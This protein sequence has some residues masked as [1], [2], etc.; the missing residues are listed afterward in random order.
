MSSAFRRLS[1]S[2]QTWVEI[3]IEGETIR[4]IKGESVAAAMLASGIRCCRTT[5]ISGKARAPFCMMGICFECLVEVDG[6]PNRQAC[7]V[8]V[9]EGMK[10][11]R[12]IG[13][14]EGYR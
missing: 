11:R 4:A 6:V 1:D 7:Q 8:S 2:D 14:A 9:E 5:A 3:Q 12:Q 10:I 13:V